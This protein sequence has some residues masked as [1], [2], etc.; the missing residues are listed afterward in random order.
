MRATCS[1]AP[2]RCEAV[3]KFHQKDKKGTHINLP[4]KDKKIK[5]YYNSKKYQINPQQN[6]SFASKFKISF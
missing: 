5:K 4:R 1:D 3:N 2:C 6:K